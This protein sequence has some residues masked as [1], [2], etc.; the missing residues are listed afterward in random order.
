[1][2]LAIWIAK[3]ASSL[4]SRRHRANDSYDATGK[5][6]GGAIDIPHVVGKREHRPFVAAGTHCDA[7]VPG[8]RRR[9]RTQTGGLFQTGCR[10]AAMGFT[11]VVEP[12]VAPE[13]ALRTSRARRHSVIDKAILSVLGNDDY[14]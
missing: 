8:R 10:Y 5:I 4:S 14:L 7:S 6:V 9:W 11:T 2:A 12:A 13:Y 3:A 1:M